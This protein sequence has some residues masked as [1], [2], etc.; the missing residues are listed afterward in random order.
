MILVVKIID[1]SDPD[2]IDILGVCSVKRAGEVYK[3]T[4]PIN[5]AIPLD[6]AIPKAMPL[7]ILTFQFI[8][9]KI[10]RSDIPVNAL[11][12]NSLDEAYL[13]PGFKVDFK[14]YF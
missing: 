14:G 12:V 10:S 2:E 8:Y 5:T 3:L 6:A 7:I 9:V 4:V 13:L 1:P 11:V